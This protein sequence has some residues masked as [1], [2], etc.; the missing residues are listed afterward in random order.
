MLGVCNTPSPL[1]GEGWDEGEGPPPPSSSL[2]RGGGRIVLDQIFN[3]LNGDMSLI[4]PRPTLVH[5]VEAY[6]SRQRKRL[7]VRPGITSWASVNGRNRLS[8]A[9]RIELDIWYVDNLSVWLDLKI[10]YKTL[11]VAFVTRD[12]VYA[13]EGANDDFGAAQAAATP[14]T[15]PEANR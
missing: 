10:L 2:L 14:K 11:W 1:T 15:E 4:G 5:Q 8:W 3:V 12:G 6:S 9:D 13:E 7:D